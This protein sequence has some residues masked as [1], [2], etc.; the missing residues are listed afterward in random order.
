MPDPMDLHL[1]AICHG[2]RCAVDRPFSDGNLAAQRPP[3]GSAWGIAPSR[4]RLC[5]TGRKWRK[6][7]R[8]CASRCSVA[9]S[10]LRTSAI[11]WPACM[12][13]R[14][15]PSTRCGCCPVPS[16]PSPSRWR[17]F[18][19]APRCTP[20]R[21]RPR[22]RARLHH[23]G[24]LPG[25][26]HPAHRARPV[27]R[28]PEHEFCLVIGADLLPERERCWHGSRAVRA[29]PLYRPGSQPAQVGRIAPAPSRQ[30]SQ[31]ATAH[32]GGRA[33]A[34][35]RHPA[36]RGGGSAA[37]QLDRGTSRTG[38][39]WSPAWLGIPERS[40]V[41]PERAL[42]VTADRSARPDPRSKDGRQERI[43]MRFD[44]V[45]RRPS[46]SAASACSSSGRDRW[47]MPCGS[48]T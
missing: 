42:Y 43:P 39:R 17:R 2:C 30:V 35:A 40:F 6:V 24:E 48:R 23:R 34:T 27:E 29:R 37:D 45:R 22:P 36:H 33:A 20:G 14:R 46:P 5:S 32:R 9:A 19:I 44:G 13:C 1:H 18:A 7:T 25:P 10:T 41:H 38:R 11:S 21:R 15:T 31:R 16:I 3:Q 26:S 28:H 12:C 8:S 4:C 47:A